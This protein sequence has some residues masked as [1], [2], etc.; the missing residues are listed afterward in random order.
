MLLPLG[1]NLNDFRLAD[2]SLGTVHQDLVSLTGSASGV[3][4][5]SCS[6]E[7][8]TSSLF[9]FRIWLRVFDSLQ[10]CFGTL[11]SGIVL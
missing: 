10:S 1:Q 5:T 2:N 6:R 11:V 8:P 4:R 3:F 9:L 7:R